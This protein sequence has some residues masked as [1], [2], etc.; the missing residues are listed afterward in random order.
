MTAICPSPE[1]PGVKRTDTG[2][3][4]A[5]VRLKIIARTS[6]SQDVRFRPCTLS[7][8]R[9]RADMRTHRRI[10][11]S[12]RDPGSVGSDFDVDA[13]SQTARTKCCW[14]VVWLEPSAAGRATRSARCTN[15]LDSPPPSGNPGDDGAALAAFAGHREHSPRDHAASGVHITL[16][17]AIS[18][19]C[20]CR[21]AAAAAEANA[22]EI[23]R[24]TDRLPA[25]IRRREPAYARASELIQFDVQRVARS[26]SRVSRSRSSVPLSLADFRPGWTI[27]ASLAFRLSA[28][29]ACHVAKMG[30]TRTGRREPPSRDPVAA[31]YVHTQ[32]RG[33]SAPLMLTCSLAHEAGRSH[34]DVKS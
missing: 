27:F 21:A 18:C 33:K 1:E 10:M 20:F 16:A 14:V 32:I 26:A 6:K 12:A 17:A 30:W 7:T 19:P 34:S 13:D 8:P 15:S 22:R 4:V 31:L 11:R 3:G 25:R 5:E 29:Y 24:A 2:K 9:C 23:E 28:W